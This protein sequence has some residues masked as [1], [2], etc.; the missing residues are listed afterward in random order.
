MKI[1]VTGAAGF[2][3]SYVAQRLVKRG[4]EVIGLDNINDYYDI[5]LKYARLKNGGVESSEVNWYQYAQ[6]HTDR[7]YKFIRM[8]L[9][10]KQAMQMLFANESFDAVCHLG[11]Q[12]GVRYSLNNPYAYIESNIVGFLNIIEGCRHSHV[13]HLIYA[14]S[15]SVYGLNA[16]I[17]YNENSGIAHPISLYAATKKSNELMAH[18][19][20]Y[21][22]QIPSTGLR[23]FTVYGPWGRPDMSPYLF[24]DA[25]LK[26]YPV[27]L[28][29]GGD[30]LRD[31]TFIDD[32]V[33]GIIRVIDHIPTPDKEWDPINPNPFSSSSAYRVYNIGNSSPVKL[34]SFIHFIEKACGKK[35][36]KI[37]L[38]MQLGDV[39]QT[40]ADTTR[41]QQ[42]I[43]YSPSI[44]V[45]E[46]VK[47]YVKWHKAYYNY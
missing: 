42:D 18:V 39:H 8:N 26:G 22:F 5:H 30:M 13:K 1:L 9:E 19:Y 15:S 41:L 25:I 43:N 29:N 23:F 28:F 31:F 44:T 4:D 2:I 27:K 11:A 34:M 24:T 36:K 16:N 35:A 3:G 37:Y 7:N 45:E 6:S 33:E 14:S 40:Y 21:L 20:S 47:H 38:P 32:I 12:A 10:D 17:P 46:G